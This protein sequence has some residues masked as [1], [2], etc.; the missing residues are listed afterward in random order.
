MAGR[1]RCLTPR[2]AKLPSGRPIRAHSPDRRVYCVTATQGVTSFRLQPTGSCHQLQAGGSGHSLPISSRLWPGF[3]PASARPLLAA[4]SAES[5]FARQNPPTLANPRY[6]RA[7]PLNPPQNIHA[8]VAPGASPCRTVRH[9]PTHDT[10]TLIS[11]AL[12]KKRSSRTGHPKMRSSRKGPPALRTLEPTYYWKER[13]INAHT[14]ALLETSIERR[15]QE[16]RTGSE[17]RLSFKS[18]IKTGGF[19]TY[20]TSV[21]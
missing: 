20:G 6:H 19:K 2:H 14:R 10:R 17:L 7:V 15:Q 21:A 11:P 18:D 8:D 3:S 16:P 4:L 13:K 1:K 9:N 5:L 12:P